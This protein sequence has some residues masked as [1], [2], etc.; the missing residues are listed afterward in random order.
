M[1]A[2][3]QAP[4]HPG[5]CYP[6][7]ARFVKLMVLRILQTSVQ[8]AAAAMVAEL[9]KIDRSEPFGSLHQK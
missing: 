4:A 3:V 7:W 9:L 5:G 1:S 8:V 6:K 2:F